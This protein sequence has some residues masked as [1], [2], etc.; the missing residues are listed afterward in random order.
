MVLCDVEGYDKVDISRVKRRINAIVLIIKSV[1]GEV[2]L[3]GNLI[4][5][6]MPV[7]ALVTIYLRKIR[8]YQSYSSL[9]VRNIV[10]LIIRCKIF[11][12][13]GIVFKLLLQHQNIN[14]NSGAAV[15]GQILFNSQFVNADLALIH[16]TSQER[17]IKMEKLPGDSIYTTD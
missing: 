17:E 15:K 6:I 9:L 14:Q 1:L 13:T 2:S 11:E 10:Q 12:I 8:H 5:A 16:F 4:L 7:F 3:T